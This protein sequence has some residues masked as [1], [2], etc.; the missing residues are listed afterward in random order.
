MSRG[1]R[2]RSTVVPARAPARRAVRKVGWG[3]PGGV[4]RE[5]LGTE[6][7]VGDVMFVV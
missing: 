4:R 7:V 3:T 1:K 6:S 5:V 2:V